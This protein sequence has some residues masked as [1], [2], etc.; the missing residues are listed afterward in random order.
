MSGSLLPNPLKANLGKQ[1]QPAERSR[2]D[3]VWVEVCNGREINKHRGPSAPASICRT[4]DVEIE[5]HAGNKAW[6]NGCNLRDHSAYPAYVNPAGEEW[7]RR[8]GRLPIA[9]QDREER[10][11]TTLPRHDGSITIAIC[12]GNSPPLGE[13]RIFWDGPDIVAAK[14]WIYVGPDDPV[15]GQ[16]FYPTLVHELGHAIGVHHNPDTNSV[17][18]EFATF[19]PYFITSHDCEALGTLGYRPASGGCGNLVSEPIL[20][21]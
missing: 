17:M 2:P 14:V 4:G 3:P 11:C 7:D 16:E 21:P 15:W 19:E 13:T 9:Y 8:T 6:R 1:G 18:Y 12:P 10:T 5:S 20:W